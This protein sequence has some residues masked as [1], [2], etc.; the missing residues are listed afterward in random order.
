MK[1]SPDQIVLAALDAVLV[2][3]A[4]VTALNRLGEETIARQAQ[5]ETTASLADS[6][7]LAEIARCQTITA[8]LPR[9]LDAR[10]N[11]QTARESEL[12]TATHHF[13][14]SALGPRSRKIQAAVREKVRAQLGPHYTDEPSLVRAVESST[15]VREV[16]KL[17]WLVKIESP[18]PTELVGY[19][20]RLL[21][22]W[23][24][25]ADLET[26]FAS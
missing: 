9:R 14:S 21:D 6:A 8:L 25:L 5:L 3:A 12:L 17:S 2:A 18:A 20:R 26:K 19:A 22:V 13:I 1:H 4:E 11:A 16:E 15:A 23:D 10:V 24:S 7:A